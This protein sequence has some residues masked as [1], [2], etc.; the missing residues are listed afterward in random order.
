VYVDDRPQ[1]VHLDV[2]EQAYA[3]LKGAG[4]GRRGEWWMIRRSPFLRL[5][6]A[7]PGH[8][9]AHFRDV[10][11]KQ[12]EEAVATVDRRSKDFQVFVLPAEVTPTGKPAT[13]RTARQAR[14]NA[15]GSIVSVSSIPQLLVVAA[16]IR[17][18]LECPAHG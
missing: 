11:P 15:L 12:A 3:A 9:S 10:W 5:L 13:R 14:D 1:E 8:V 7:V 2:R 16:A 18:L 4:Y 6:R 17:A